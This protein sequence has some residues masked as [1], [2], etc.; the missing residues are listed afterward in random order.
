MEN[1]NAWRPEQDTKSG[2]IAIWQ[3][4]RE[5]IY[6]GCHSQGVLPGGLNVQRLASDVRN[7]FRV[8]EVGKEA[9]LQT[10]FLYGGCLNEVKEGDVKY[11]HRIGGNDN[12]SVAVFYIGCTISL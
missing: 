1:E 9:L 4:M 10:C 2:V 5:C 11:Q 12:G 3:V 8:I 6:R 7:L